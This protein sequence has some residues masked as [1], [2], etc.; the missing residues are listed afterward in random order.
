M[1][2]VHVFEIVEAVAHL[3]DLFMLNCYNTG[4]MKY[5]NAKYILKYCPSLKYF[6]FSSELDH[7]SLWSSSASGV[8]QNYQ[9]KVPR[10]CF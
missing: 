7:R 9:T 10:N 3:P 2:H 5:W 8:V 6:I 1:P 4:D